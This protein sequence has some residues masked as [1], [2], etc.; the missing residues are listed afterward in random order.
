M[1]RVTTLGFDAHSV[2][3]TWH[4]LTEHGFGKFDM[5]LAKLD[6]IPPF[7]V[8]LNLAREKV[9]LM[10]CQPGMLRVLPGGIPQEAKRRI[11]TSR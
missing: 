8:A 3:D 1:G 7:L 10:L 5:Y 2:L 4:G 6:S 9:G 11:K